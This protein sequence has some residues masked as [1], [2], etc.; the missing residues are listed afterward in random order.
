MIPAHLSDEQPFRRIALFL[1]ALFG[2][3]SGPMRSFG[4]GAQGV[5]QLIQFVRNRPSSAP[6]SV[7]QRQDTGSRS[8]FVE[9]DQRSLL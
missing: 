3:F 1:F 5:D 4:S 7:F 8:G 6:A 2:V 9:N